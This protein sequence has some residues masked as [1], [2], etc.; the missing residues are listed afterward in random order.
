MTLEDRPSDR[1]VLRAMF[2]AP[3][4]GLLLAIVMALGPAP[5][6]R[7]QSPDYA[8]EVCLVDADR[9]RISLQTD[10]SVVNALVHPLPPGGG[11][12]L[13]QTGPGSF[14]REFTSSDFGSGPFSFRLVLQ[15]PAQY[16]FPEHQIE[17]SPDCRSFRRDDVV[18]P[19][20]RGFHTEVIEGENS[21][22]IEFEAS[23]GG[24]SIPATS[25]VAMR[26]RIDD[27]E[28]LRRTMTDDGTGSF[29]IDLPGMS[30]GSRLEY[31]FEQQVGLQ[32]VESSLFQHRFGE[33]EPE[34]IVFP[35]VARTA[36]RFR[37]RHPNE[38]RFD[39]YVEN[40]DGGKT[41][42]IEI[43][44]QGDRLDLVVTTDRTGGPE[45]IDIGY[46]IQSGPGEMCE[47]PLTVNNLVMEPESDRPHVF[48]RR[49][50]DVTVGQIVEFDLTHIGVPNPAGGTFQYYTEFFH[51]HVGRGWFATARSNPRA[52]AAGRASI[53]RVTAPRFAFAQHASNLTLEQ[54]GR[55]MEGKTRFET[56]HRDGLLLNFPTSFACCT[57]T[58]GIAFASS[59]HARV[60]ELGP[61]FSE[62]SCIGCHLMDGRGLTPTG[63]EETLTSLVMHLSLGAENGDGRPIPHPDYGLQ[64]DPGAA[65]GGHSEGR[66][67]VEYD[68][69]EGT[70]DDGTPYELRRPRYLF[71]DTL[72]GSPGRNLPDTDGTPGY[73]GIV[74]ASPRIAPIL[75]G[76]G[77][78]EAVDESAILAFADPDDLDGDGISGRPNWVIDLETDELVLGRFGWKASQP[79][80]LQ[81]TAVAYQRDLGLTSPLTPRHDCGSLDESCPEDPTEELTAEDVRLVADYVRGLTLP[82]RRNHEDPAAIE[83]MHLFRRANCQACHVPSLR[84]APDHE[85][86]AYRNDVIQPFTD[87]LLH[88]MGPGLADGF[89]DHAAGGS[90]WRT[91][92]L[93]GAEFVG[94]A[95]TLP[96]TCEDPFSGD[97]TPNYLHDGRARSLMEAILWHG[98]EAAASRDSVLAMTAVERTSLLAFLAYPFADPLLERPARSPCPADFDRD[99][100]VDAA[101]L[102]LMLE[103]WGRSGTGDLDGDGTVDS[104]DLGLLFIAW[105]PCP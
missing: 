64:F 12:Y 1:S 53:D 82:P 61:R 95:Q 86:A 75:A 3:V 16:G 27:G 38:W 2:G 66:L 44:D 94:H 104:A 68:V 79:T 90:E 105:G 48:R 97:S 84:T 25:E 54:L 76:T 6:V 35:I 14:E 43:T 55:F 57:E 32:S 8:G 83:G 18:P 5:P 28:I 33:P 21:V 24:G 26:Y 67:R 99:G 103:A 31:W 20:P 60:N 23:P 17:L 92:P 102:G 59:P 51:Y 74:Q 71:Q 88:D 77:L 89:D 39:H 34:P 22:R 56:D 40:Y 69:V 80:L 100:T 13:D 78:I 47:R 4:P 46:F 42:E 87:L 58:G 70:F 7:A 73:P 45:R 37:D 50:P 10:E 91:P 63:E 11:W 98:G 65:N 101:D 96:V 62:T 85:I 29:I 30:E 19:P 93:W 52:L 41:F 36:A 9:V 81:Q 15:N 72:H 49:I